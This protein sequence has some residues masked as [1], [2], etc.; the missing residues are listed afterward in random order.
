VRARY[1]CALL[2]VTGG[3]RCQSGLTTPEVDPLRLQPAS[4]DFGRVYVGGQ[5]SLTLTLSNPARVAQPYEAVVAP[6]FFLNPSSG[7]VGAGSDVVISVTFSPSVAAPF[8]AVLLGTALSGTG[9][10]PLD[11][12]DAGACT[13]IGFDADAGACVST[14]LPDGMDCTGSFACFTKAACLSGACVGAIDTCDDGNACTIDSCGALGCAHTDAIFTCPWPQNPCQIPTCDPSSGCGITNAPDGTLC[15]A[16]DCSTAQ[17]CINGQCVIRPAPQTAACVD[18]VA[19]TP[20]S[21]G[22][23]D[24]FGVNARFSQ[25]PGLATD[26]SGNVWVADLEN[27]EI[28]RVTPSGQVDT[29]AGV[30]WE[31]GNT[32]GFRDR[33]RLMLPSQIV[34][35]S[36]GNL[37][38]ADSALCQDAARIRKMTP[39]GLVT[40]FAGG[41]LTAQRDGIGPAAGFACIGG[42]A[43]GP[44]DVLWVADLESI[45]RVS[46]SGE[47]TT[48][49]SP[50]HPVTFTLGSIASQAQLDSTVLRVTTGLAVAPEGLWV[51]LTRYPWA[52]GALAWSPPFQGD[53][54]AIAIAPDGTLALPGLGS[55]LLP[56]GQRVSLP[57]LGTIWSMAW[58]GDGKWVAAIAHFE[59]GTRLVTIDPTDMSV[60]PLA[61]PEDPI[62]TFNGPSGVLDLPDGT[63]L[64]GVGQG[65][66]TVDAGQVV[67]WWRGA[68]VADLALQSDGSP[69]G[70]GGSA[71]MTMVGGNLSKTPTPDFLLSVAV[72]EG[73][74]AVGGPNSVR[75]LDGGNLYPGT[76][77]LGC[78]GA[79][80][81]VLA[82]ANFPAVID[83]LADG[84]ER[85]LEADVGP[86]DGGSGDGFG[87]DVRLGVVSGIAR[88]PVSGDWFIASQEP[89]NA[90][91]QMTQLGV[92]RTVAGLSDPPQ[93]IFVEDG[94]TLLVTVPSAVLRIRP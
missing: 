77:A 24:G 1:L 17:V 22:W 85:I 2:L 81:L 57:P 87:S 34:V 40:T 90:I 80:G 89:F 93:R 31:T 60:A 56:T 46:P 26:R 66:D 3:C 62:G 28:R 35:D 23:A 59:N 88:D 4:L 41:I 20:G 25:Y 47:V 16:R 51:G 27:A 52:S 9:L 72:C 42:I 30:H 92:V 58:R 43:I 38:I 86:Y 39:Q 29:I 14:T 11:C 82:S 83:L 63:V 44:D 55:L 12:G 6:P 61:G 94:G 76:T 91:R 64:V 21:P 33:A 7:S 45:R 71:I 32:D 73:R 53:P 68:A 49:L 65:I 15:G 13:A 10:A 5:R 50:P 8:T 18:I 78:D 54:G 84:G 70:V 37:F 67:P 79:G 69:V 74:V 19:G 48:W 36:H 75:W